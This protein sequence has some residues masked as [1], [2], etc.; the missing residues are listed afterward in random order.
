MN[1]GK[2]LRLNKLFGN[3]GRTFIVAIDHPTYGEIR[4]LERLKPLVKSIKEGGVDGF[5]ANPGAI[6]N[7]LY[8]LPNTGLIMTIPYAKEYVKYA[9][10]IGV[11]AIKT[12]YFGNPKMKESDLDKISMIVAEAEEWGIP[13]I[14]ELI[15]IDENGKYIY[16]ADTLKVICRIGA[17]LGADIIKTVYAGPQDKFRDVIETSGVPIIVAGGEKMSSTSD[18]IKTIW[19]AINSGAAGA[20]I[21]RNVW[22]SS[23]PK[24]VSSTMWKIIHNQIELNN[25][26]EILGV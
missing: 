16:N 4:G 5:L 13:Y 8:D 6:A 21:G 2:R 1:T 14:L 15:P 20:A 25:A 24:L 18:F 22:Q 17:E 23:N 7:V 9:S 12:A 11:D 19:E 3:D 26:F 10:K